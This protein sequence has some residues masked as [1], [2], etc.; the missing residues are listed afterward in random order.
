MSQRDTKDYE[1]PPS[2]ESSRSSVVLNYGKMIQH[3][4]LAHLIPHAL[5]RRHVNDGVHHCNRSIQAQRS[6]V[7]CRY[8][9]VAG[10]RERG[11]C[12]SNYGSRHD[13]APCPVNSRCTADL[14][15]DVLGL[16]AVDQ[17]NA[18]SARRSSNAHGE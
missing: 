2:R 7:Q 5:R 9:G 15:K 6:A 13:T 1:N 4:L 11:S 14:P 16:G 12:R 3:V 8:Y 10:S 17:V 18:A